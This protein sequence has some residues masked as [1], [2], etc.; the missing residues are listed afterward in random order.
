[1]LQAAEFTENVP[2]ITV[3]AVIVCSP[4]FRRQPIRGSPTANFAEY[5]A[6]VDGS[7]SVSSSMQDEV[8]PC[9]GVWSWYPLDPMFDHE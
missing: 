7:M 8:I 9:L 4:A 6:H 5:M 3:P 1:M 2:V